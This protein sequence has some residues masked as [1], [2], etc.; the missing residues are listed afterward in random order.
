MAKVCLTVFIDSLGGSIS[1][2]VMP[3][4]AEEFHA[5]SSEVGHESTLGK[6]ADRWLPFV[7]LQLG[8]PNVA[9][10]GGSEVEAK[11]TSRAQFGVIFALGGVIVLPGRLALQHLLVGASDCAASAWPPCGSCWPAAG[12]GR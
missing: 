12:A 3:F 11:R 10:Y 9:R 5:S 4:Y 1:A 2:P 6:G 8:S 7:R